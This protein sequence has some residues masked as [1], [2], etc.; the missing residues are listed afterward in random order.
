[1][2]FKFSLFSLTLTTLLVGTQIA[3]WQTNSVAIAQTYQ[4]SNRTPIADNKLGTQVSASGN[5]FTITGGLNKGQVLFHSFTDFSVPTNG[6]ANFAK[7]V[8]NRDIITRVT[9]NLFSDINGL[10]NTNGANLFL[11]NPNG[12]V[13][14]TN[15]QLNVG[16]AF[17]GSTANSIDLV[18]PGGQKITFGTNSTGDAPLISIAPNVLFNVANLN[19]GSGSGQISIFGTLQTNNQSQYIGLIGGNVKLDGG[20]I[21]AP[22]GRVDLGGLN[23]AGAVSVNSNG[24]VFNGTNLTR[25]DVSIANNSS[26]SVRANQ[27]LNPIDPVFFTNAGSPGSSINISANRID[28]INSGDRFIPNQQQPINQKLGGLDAGLEVNSGA[29]TGTIGNINLDATGDI[30]IQ[31][32]AIFNLVRSGSE[33][34]G[35]GIK[36]SGNNITVTDKSEIS[37]NLFENAAGRGGDI[38]IIAKGNFSLSEPNYP[39]VVAPLNFAESVIAASTFGRG[40]SGK[41]KIAAGGSV[42]ISDNDVIASTVEATGV[43]DGG[44]IKIDASSFTLRNGSQILTAVNTSTTGQQGNAG[45]IDITSTGD[46]TIAGSKAPSVLTNIED[47]SKPLAKI[48]SS[49]FRSGNAG[50]VTLSAPGKVKIVNRAAILSQIRANGIGN[51]GGITLDVGELLLSN[52]SEIS[53]SVGTATE[54]NA[55]GNTGDISIK[56][57][58]NITL[59]EDRIVRSVEENNFAPS[60]ISSS[61]NGIGNGGKIAIATPGKVSVGNRNAIGNTVEST[62]Q[63]NSGGITINAGELVVFNQGQIL[64]GAQQAPDGKTGNAGNIDI[65]TSGNIT[66]AGNNNANAVPATSDAFI[67]KIASS[68]FR[69]GNAGKIT[70]DA[71][72]KILLINK[73]GI[74]TD[75]K[76]TSVGNSSGDITINSKQLNLDRGNIS[77]E[78]TD[79]GG[80]L[81]IATQDSMAI[82][83][84][85][86]ISTSATNGQAG[87]IVLSSPQITLDNGKIVAQSSS[88]KGGNIKI[89]RSELLLL[90]RGSL[91]SANAGGTSQ[92]GD[93]GGNIAIDSKLLVALTT[94]NSDLTANAVKGRG[95]NVTI[96]AQAIFGIQYRPQQTANSDITASS[97]FGQSG[98]VNIVTPNI[99]PNRDTQALPTV[100]TDASNQI[101][102]VCS[103]STRQNKL[104]VAGRGGLP[105]NAN[106]PLTSDVV[107]QDSRTASSQPAV[108]SATSA[109][110][111]PPAVGWVFNDRGKVTLIAAGTDGQPTTTS[112]ICPQE[113]K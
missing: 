64:T 7:P 95:G 23:T 42:I 18:A 82:G 57:T 43:G 62:G 106:D 32:A 52:L 102:Q 103:A 38:D 53:S 88:G 74:I 72:G 75:R 92:V 93:D 14:G 107:W 16:K 98:A 55:R 51:S 44:G 65:K 97:D 89:D 35:G 39:D 34:T 2:L 9:G 50:K 71:G 105:P 26:V 113:V 47:R 94:E 101:S 66:V 59:D 5:N 40:N 21:I 85:S 78:A 4:P 13:F 48:A 49:N 25:S 76:S 83:N 6:Q 108:S 30:K 54:S 104:T 81:K 61:M 31:R 90:R 84:N 1:M 80:N 56:A 37:T 109:N 91:I 67:A 46:I 19:I 70:I 3:I 22:G 12:I 99:D 11:I 58:G 60:V 86:S 77:V 33:G 15:A 69:N 79:N 28:L 96:K 27:T 17:V 112:T 111:A 29:K 8:G 68:S 41:I 73:G 24:L 45:N 63:G 10:V 87:E 36:I 110:F 100:P 20:K